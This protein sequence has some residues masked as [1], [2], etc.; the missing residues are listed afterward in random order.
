[1]LEK[2]KEKGRNAKEKVIE[3]KNDPRIIAL[4]M[5]EVMLSVIIAFSVYFYLDPT[6]NFSVFPEVVFPFNLIAFIALFAVFIYIF[7][8]TKEFRKERETI[9]QNK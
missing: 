9:T 6:R 5:L 7:N 1:M 8:L 2:V 3:A 4:V